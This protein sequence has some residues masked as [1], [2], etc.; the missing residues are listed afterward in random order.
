[1]E[2]YKVKLL[3]CEKVKYPGLDW[4][5]PLPLTVHDAINRIVALPKL[6][7]YSVLGLRKTASL[8]EIKQAKNS[9]TKF[10]S[11]EIVSDFFLIIILFLGA[12]SWCRSGY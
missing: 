5:V 7:P 9:L 3:G 11:S 4:N 1:M 12:L 8:E 2:C 10:L 6:D